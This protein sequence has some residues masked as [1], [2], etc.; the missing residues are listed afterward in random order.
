MC[1]IKGCITHPVFNLPSETPG[2]CS[3]HKT[4][5]M[6]DVKHKLCQY[7]EL[8]SSIICIKRAYYNFENI[9]EGGIFCRTHKEENMINIHASKKEC[10]HEGCKLYPSFNY[11]GENNGQYCKTHMLENMV[12][13]KHKKCNFKHCTKRP[14]FNI[15]GYTYALY[16]TNHRLENMVD[17]LN[18]ICKF[19][20]CIK[21]PH[22]NVTG[23]KIG[24]YCTDHKLKDMIDVINKS[25]I[26]K[27]FI[28]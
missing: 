8:N 11:N 6:I 22:F 16:C 17:V 15:K 20:G 21:Q 12:D 23:S 25:S 27:I 14:T 24:I 13:V 2:F 7:K 3:K 5:E 18:K 28:L 1:N 10:L 19:E 4:P 9:N 26:C